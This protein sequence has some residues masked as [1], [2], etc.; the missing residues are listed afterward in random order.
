MSV[1]G[2]LEETELID[3]YMSLYRPGQN[4]LNSDLRQTDVAE[5]GAYRAVLP[6]IANERWDRQNKRH[7][8]AT[9]SFYSRNGK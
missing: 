9:L 6:A 2:N 4:L 7:P 3:R 5:I 1:G 8:K